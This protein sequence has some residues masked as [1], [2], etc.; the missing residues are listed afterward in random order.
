ME[1]KELQDVVKDLL[2]ARMDIG[3]IAKGGAVDVTKIL[4]PLSNL[5]SD[6][7]KKLGK[8]VFSKE[9]EDLLKP[10]IKESKD[11]LADADNSN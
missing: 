6:I 3:E 5:V 8:G 9:V 7:E 11:K 10:I 1:N 4:S 2:S